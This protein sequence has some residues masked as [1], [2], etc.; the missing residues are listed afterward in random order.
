MFEET[1]RKIAIIAFESR[2]S[3]G[4]EKKRASII[5]F[6]PANDAEDRV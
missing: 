5:L 3:G 6:E 1:A 2:L 4:A